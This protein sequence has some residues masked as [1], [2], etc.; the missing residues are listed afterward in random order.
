MV[1][2]MTLDLP[3]YEDTLAALEKVGAYNSQMI[4]PT[5]EAP[6]VK[7]KEELRADLNILDEQLMEEYEL[8]KEFFSSDVINKLKQ[9]NNKEMDIGSGKGTVMG[10]RNSIRL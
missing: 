4:I 2:K 9:Q 3:N 5:D 6:I 8:M 10:S 7:F 1:N